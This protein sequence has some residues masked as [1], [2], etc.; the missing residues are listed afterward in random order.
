MSEEEKGGGG[1]GF[2]VIILLIAILVVYSERP[3]GTHEVPDPHKPPTTTS[4]GR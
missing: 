2:W 1:G 4:E 3:H